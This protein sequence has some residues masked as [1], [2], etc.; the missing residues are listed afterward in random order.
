MTRPAIRE[1]GERDAPGLAELLRASPQAGR[2]VVAQDRD[3]DVF[4][5]RRPFPAA[6]TL[7]VDDGPGGRR[8][9]D[10]PAAAVTVATKGVL[11]DGAALTAGYV[12]DLAVAPGARRRGLG[13]AL[14]DAAAS[15][16]EERGAALLYAHVVAGNVASSAVF[17]GAGY[18]PAARIATRIVPAHR[19][20]PTPPPGRLEVADW[21][22]A[23]AILGAAQR[24]RDLAVPLD[25][26]GLAARWRS[27][28]GYRPDDVWTTGRSLLGLWDRRGVVRYRPT[29]LPPEVRA[30][31]GLARLAERVGVPFPAAPRADTP[32]ATGYLLGGGGDPA[33]LAA[34]FRA[35]LG[36]ARERGLQHVVAFHDRRIRP[37]WLRTAIQVSETNLLLSRPLRDRGP[38]TALGRRPVVVDPIDM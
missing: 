29:S 3:P 26:P 16:A 14:L 27:L 22:R 5:R 13:D 32:I 1:A 24:D 4:A 25:G 15:W 33:E 31:G 2:L 17:S 19:R 23:A 8:G 30:L 18:R 28:P 11:V 7:V 12:F 35:V 21:E 37:S 9:P 34:L 38:A 36:R 20:R 10:P 6:V